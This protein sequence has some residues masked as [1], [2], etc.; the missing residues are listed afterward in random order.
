VS[1][2]NP[3]TPKADPFSLKAGGSLCSRRPFLLLE[4][5]GRDNLSGMGEFPTA[6]LEAERAGFDSSLIEESLALSYEQRAVQHQCALDLAL[7]ME[8]AGRV[9]RE[10]SQ[11]TSTASLR[12]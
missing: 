1:E 3:R 6:I 9:M 11:S 5:P 10:Q 7:E 12:R 4:L 8:R 2:R